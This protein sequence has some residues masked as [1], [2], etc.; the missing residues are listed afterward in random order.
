MLDKRVKF[1]ADYA[2]GQDENCN[3]ITE[4]KAAETYAE[5]KAPTR[6]EFYQANQAGYKISAVVRV[7]KDTYNGAPFIVSDG[8]KYRIRRAF[9]VSSV[10]LELSVEEVI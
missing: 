6:T 1:I 8:I 4:E 5:F 10:F 2:N 3:A 9:P 7:Y